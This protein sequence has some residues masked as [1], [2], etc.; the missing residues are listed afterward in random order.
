MTGETSTRHHQS[1][2]S[3]PA[4]PIP[5]SC[6]ACFFG[7]GSPTTLARFCMCE[8]GLFLQSPLASFLGA[9]FAL[10]P[11][12]GVPQTSSSY[13][14]IFARGKAVPDGDGAALVHRELP[15]EWWGV[16]KAQLVQLGEPSL[17]GCAYL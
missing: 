3:I 16:G 2:S 7:R 11:Y 14:A 12:A 5:P 1:R 15:A 13:E 10:V 9:L 17:A 8:K 4:L 6:Q